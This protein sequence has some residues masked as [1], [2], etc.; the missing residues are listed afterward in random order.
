MG[1]TMIDANVLTE[2]ETKA[3][4][5]PAGGRIKVRATK[6]GFAGVVR[7]VG[8]VFEMPAGS[9]GSWFVPVETLSVG[10][11]KTKG[12]VLSDADLI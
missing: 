5:A 2:K 1:K 8:E 6:R 12:S 4:P 7:D 10:K 9:K 3:A 11:I